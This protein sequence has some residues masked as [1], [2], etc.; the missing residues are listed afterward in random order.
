MNTGVLVEGDGNRED[1]K[2]TGKLGALA[3]QGIPS[4]QVTATTT[5]PRHLVSSP[6]EPSRPDGFLWDMFCVRM[7]PSSSHE[8][9]SVPA[10]IKQLF[11]LSPRCI[12]AF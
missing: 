7:A 11:V 4:S 8:G 6:G 10:G 3:W 12:C 5:M 1:G 9:W 2:L